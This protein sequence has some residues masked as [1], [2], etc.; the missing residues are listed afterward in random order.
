M[1]ATTSN[2][3]S[4]RAGAGRE[5]TAAPPQAGPRRTVGTRLTAAL[6]AVVL[7]AGV[8]AVVVEP[9]RPAA[10]AATAEQEASDAAAGFFGRYV[11]ADGRVVR[12]D[13]GGDTVSEGQAYAMLIAVGVGDRSGF[14]RVWG[15][16][17]TNLQRADGLLAWHWDGGRVVDDQPATDADLDAAW[18]LALAG[19]RWGRP[20]LTAE[21]ARIGAAILAHQVIGTAR[22]P[23]L[24][25]GPWAVA[26][27]WANPSY[28]SPAAFDVLG[29]IT[30]D[31][32]WAALAESARR[33]ATE[34]TGTAGVVA[35][36]A[37]VGSDGSV[38]ATAAPGDGSDTGP[39]AGYEAHRVPIRFALD[40]T[41]AGQAVARRWW[42]FAQGRTDPGPAPVVDLD[43]RP[44]APGTHASALAA[45]AAAAEASGAHDSADRLWDRATSHDDRHPTYFGSALVALGRLAIDTPTLGGCPP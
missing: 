16:A 38:R 18:A 5:P 14:D 26:D 33:L 39:V 32:T 7:G 9:D 4:H 44:L 30:G 15:W 25:A 23:V 8:L 13:Q 31:P 6:A 41:D 27:G 11:D 10:A 20:D 40:C 17:A 43:G 22:G 42:G 45:S 34:S 19:E 2:L 37:R 28:G 24:A 29:R 21:A 1:T 12:H 35:D 36:W 3:R